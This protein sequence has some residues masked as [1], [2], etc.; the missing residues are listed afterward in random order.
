MPLVQVEQAYAD[1]TSVRRPLIPAIRWGAVIAGVAVGISVQ[2]ALSLLGI[3][4]GLSVA[5]VSGGRAGL[6]RGALI[7][8]GFSMLVAAFVG[9]YVAARMTGLKR[10]AD[11]VLHGVVTWSVTTLLFATLASSASGSFLGNMFS[12]VN[13][14]S[15]ISSTASGNASDVA[16]RMADIIR[17]ETGVNLTQDRLR[18]LQQYIAA[19]ERGR[20]VEYMA[21]AIGIDQARAGSIVDQALIASGSAAQASARGQAQ[22]SQALDSAGLAAWTVFGSVALS[23][24]LGII[25]GLFGSLGSRRTTWSEEG[26]P[27]AMASA[28]RPA[29]SP[30]A[31]VR[32]PLDR[33]PQGRVP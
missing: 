26:E 29:A 32:D 23:L 27:L 18:T 3:A 14:G 12:S 7:W 22:A 11:G 33:N 21:G 28:A 24:V 6:A 1:A 8:A 16:S 31:T 20:A 4:T 5:D 2:L 30:N 25:G 17:A 19:G 10:K 13:S 9:G 15:V